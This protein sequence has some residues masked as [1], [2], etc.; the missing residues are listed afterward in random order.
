MTTMAVDDDGYDSND[1]MVISPLNGETTMMMM[2]TMRSY[3]CIVA[4]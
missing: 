4:S 1:I 3:S 2:T